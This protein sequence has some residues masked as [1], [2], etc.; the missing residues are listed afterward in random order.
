MKRVMFILAIALVPLIGFASGTTEGKG[1]VPTIRFAHTWGEGDAKSP[2]FVPALQ[3]FVDA[4]ASEFKVV[5]ETASGDNMF[6]KIQVDLAGDSLPDIWTYWG[7]SRLVPLVEGGKLLDIDKYLAVT[8]ALKRSDI[9]DGAWNLYQVGKANYGIPLEGYV[10][11]FLVN[12]DLF[13]KYG[14]SYPKTY[15][16]FVSVGKVFQQNNIIPF[17][18]GSQGGNPSHFWFS[19]VYTQFPGAVDELV[20]LPQ[21]KQFA[22]EN[23]LRTAQLMADMKAQ[24]LFPKDTLANGDWGPSFALYNEGKAAMVYT[25]PWMLGQMSKEMQTKSVPIAV[26]RMPGATQD[27]TTFISGGAVFGI[28]VNK[29]SF[30]S[31]AKQKALIALMDFMVSDK[32]F[33]EL[34]KGGLIPTKKYNMNVSSFNDVMRKVLDFTSG[35]KKVTAHWWNIWDNTAAQVY[36][37]SLDELFAG[38]VTPQQF[39]DKVQAAFKK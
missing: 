36:Q 27:P 39:V 24:G 25:Y 13:K 29:A 19:E 16:D 30:E 18:M 9:G 20:N 37:S 8:K 28:V 3:K 35:M 12:A 38:V 14:L 7:G 22:T 31:P 10:A 26:P 17:A 32:L 23:A 11:A 1:A 33:D 21:T 2:Y 15:E 4:H 6:N 34:I 5:T